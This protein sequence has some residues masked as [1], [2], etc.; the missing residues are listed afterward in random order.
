MLGRRSK[1]GERELL[2]SRQRAALYRNRKARRTIAGRSS[3]DA[4]MAVR[5]TDGHQIT[6]LYSHDTDADA[7]HGAIAVAGAAHAAGDIPAHIGM[8]GT[9]RR[10]LSAALRAA[11]G[12]HRRGGAAGHTIA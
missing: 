7:E 10:V 6:E 8:Q 12:N 5:N 9:C 2:L 11:V 1:L 3:A 4:G